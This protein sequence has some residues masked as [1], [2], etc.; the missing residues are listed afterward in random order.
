MENILIVD[1]EPGIR[2]ILTLSLADL[3]YTVTSASSGEEALRLLEQ[4]TPDIVLADIKMPGIDGVDLLRRVKSQY[5]D[6]EVIMIS[7]HG[8]MDLAI[9]S[10][11][12]QAV[13]F[14]TKPIRDDMLQIALGRATERIAS[15]RR[16]A[17]YTGRLEQMVQEQSAKVVELER[18]LAVGQ[19]VEGLAQAVVDLTNSVGAEGGLFNALP[20]SVAVHDRNGKVVSTN[21]LYRERLGDRIGQASCLVYPGYVPGQR[22]CPVGRTI[23][24]GKPQQGR[25]TMVTVTGENIPVQVHTAPIFG[26]DGEV[27]LVLELAVD[28]SE[29]KRLQEELTEAQDHLTHLGLMLGSMSHGVKGMLM[30]LDGGIFRLRLGLER[31]DAE[32]AR[33][34]FKTVA[35]RVEMIKKMILDILY[36]A[37]SRELTRNVVD[38][39]V[40]FGEVADTVEPKA[41]NA[42]ARLD[43]DID[44]DL[45]ALSIDDVALATAL[46]NILENAVDAC[47]SDTAKPTHAVA[48]R[49]RKDAGELVVEVQ[50]DGPGMSEETREKMFTLFFSSKGSK[51]TGL[52][53]FIAHRVVKQHGGTIDVQ[54]QPGAGSRFVLRLP[55]EGVRPR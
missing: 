12:L 45:G 15:R 3:G 44:P 50:D 26:Q 20:C 35:Y 13:D 41:K 7:G 27:E 21:Q 28:I 31:A 53:L 16:I 32:K 14:V 18:K 10:L 55:W 54:S 43:R 38:G 40:F 19:A 30:A 42:G 47:A 9:K 2:Q 6:I 8:D 1:D 33:E 5:P 23:T 52:G 48:F 11:Q 37:K 46:V 25:E 4:A 34:G 24:T 39:S 22:T 17:E 36:Y 51:G 49:V 29:V